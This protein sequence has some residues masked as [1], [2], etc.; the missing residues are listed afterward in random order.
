[1]PRSLTVAAA[2]A[3]K[4]DP[5]LKWYAIR[6]KSNFERV[7]AEALRARGLEEF[8]PLYVRRR[9]S[10]KVPLF[11]GY[12]FGRFDIERRLAVLTVPG[13][14]HVVSFGRIPAEVDET[15]I[16]ALKIA[17]NSGLQ[18]EPCAFVRIGQRVMIDAGP[19]RGV[20]GIVIGTRKDCR[21]VLSVTLLQRSVAVE[22]E[23]ACVVAARPQ[24]IPIRRDAG[25]LAR[26]VDTPVDILARAAEAGS[27]P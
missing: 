16:A 22:I 19:L 14:V 18:L 20:E 9:G 23:Q 3:Q 27:R 6:V 7:T 26:A 25:L 1:M 24:P 10:Q 12:I 21:L 5:A 4:V 13:V 2:C 11:P 15:E 8:L 17:V